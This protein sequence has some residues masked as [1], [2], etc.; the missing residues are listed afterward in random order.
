[1]FAVLVDKFNGV[2]DGHRVGRM[3]KIELVGQCRKILC[4]GRVFGFIVQNTRLRDPA[5]S[6]DGQPEDDLAAKG[7]AETAMKIIDP[8][9]FAYV[10]FE[11]AIDMCTQ[12][13]FAWVGHAGIGAVGVD[14]GAGAKNEG[15]CDRAE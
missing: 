14:I 6:R 2:A 5:F 3:A 15:E 10:L 8:V 7:A 9:Q 1:M 4:I 12:S 13:R 11:D